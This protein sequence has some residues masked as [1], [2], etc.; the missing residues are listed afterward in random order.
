MQDSDISVVGH[1]SIDS[2]RLPGQIGSYIILGGSITYVALAAR[3]LEGS[4]ALFS[5]VG[6]DFPEAYFWWLEQEGIDITGVVKLMQDKTTRFDLQYSEEFSSRILSLKAQGSPICT[7]DLPSSMQAKITHLAPIDGEISFELAE[8]LREQSEL[9]SLDPQGLL[10]RFDSGG[11]VT[12][13]HSS[14]K[15][16]LNIID[17]YKSSQEEIA[18]FTGCSDIDSAIKTVHDLG[19]KIVI[20]TSGPSGS[21]LSAEKTV[22]H[23]PACSSSTVID[24]TG[25]GDVFIGG[26]L[27]EYTRQKDP[28][29]CACVGSAAASLVV[30]VV[31]PR[32]LRDKEE[33]Y[34]RAWCIYEKEIK[35]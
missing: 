31:G 4:V 5:K 30:E 23:I 34:R 24:P 1:F 18:A 6:A 28:L 20:V 26:F 2:I 21:L 3:R 11:K 22:Y 7:F 12:I 10:R 9:L 33:L 19:V 32:F 27:T 35:Q 14:N 8:T 25:A 15:N 13:S 29:W 16:F 17:I